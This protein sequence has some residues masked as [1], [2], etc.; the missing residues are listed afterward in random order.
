MLTRLELGGRYV[1]PLFIEAER[2]LRVRTPR[3]VIGSSLPVR[4]PVPRTTECGA[5]MQTHDSQESRATRTTRKLNATR[6]VA[7]LALRAMP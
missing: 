1:L 7:V 2:E 5:R 6:S 3:S 4:R